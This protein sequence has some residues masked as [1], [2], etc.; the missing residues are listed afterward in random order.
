[1]PIVCDSCALQIPRYRLVKTM[2]EH[3]AIEDAL[4]FLD[5]ALSNG[6]ID[7]NVF[8]KEV[9][10]LSRKQF[11]CQALAQKIHTTQQQRTTPTYSITNRS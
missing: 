7:L 6:E 8:L 2:A 11:M 10:K 3:Q 4:Y 1:M 5:R 9:R